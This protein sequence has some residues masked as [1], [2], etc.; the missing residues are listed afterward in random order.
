MNTPG[1]SAR[2]VTA[3][4]AS[5]IQPEIRNGSGAGAGAASR[6]ARRAALLALEL[7]E[8]PAYSPGSDLFESQRAGHVAVDIGQAGFGACRCGHQ[9]LSAARNRVRIVRERGD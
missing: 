8:D 2:G 9:R 6:A 5:A 7:I 4:A 1:S 3:T